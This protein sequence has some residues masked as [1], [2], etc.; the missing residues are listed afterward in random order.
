VTA[1]ATF[2]QRLFSAANKSLKIWDIET[3]TS[4]SELMDFGLVKDIQISN[5]H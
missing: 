2:E 1:V 5:K 3:M 4:V